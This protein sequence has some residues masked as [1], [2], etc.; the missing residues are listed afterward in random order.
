MVFSSFGAWTACVASRSSL[1][2]RTLFHPIIFFR[3]V[4]CIKSLVCG[5]LDGSALSFAHNPSDVQREA[6]KN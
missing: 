6:E 1:E 3:L 2:L 5:S 4:T